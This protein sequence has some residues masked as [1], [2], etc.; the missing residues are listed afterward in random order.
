MKTIQR[1]KYEE[2]HVLHNSRDGIVT[3]IEE[4]ED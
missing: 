2:I 3:N 4:L 1:K